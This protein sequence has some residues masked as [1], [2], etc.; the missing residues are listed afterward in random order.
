MLDG[1]TRV[2]MFQAVGTAL[3]SQSG[4]ML[5]SN[6]IWERFTNLMRCKPK[7]GAG[8][9]CRGVAEYTRQFGMENKCSETRPTWHPKPEPEPYVEPEPETRPTWHSKPEPEPYT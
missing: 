6:H 4:Y 2:V 5:A 1:V 7:G 9:R 8:R 3:F